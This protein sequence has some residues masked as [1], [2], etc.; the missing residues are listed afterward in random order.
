MSALTAN[1]LA[2]VAA[3][4]EIFLARKDVPAALLDHLRSLGVLSPPPNLLHLP[5]LPKPK[6]A[7]PSVGESDENVGGCPHQQDSCS[8]MP[9]LVNQHQDLRGLKQL[10]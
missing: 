3:D 5:G 6:S 2:D 10:L 8:T 7:L 4:I 1:A 9:K